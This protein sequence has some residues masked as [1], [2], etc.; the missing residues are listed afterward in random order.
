MS[1]SIPGNRKGSNPRCWYNKF[2][3]TGSNPVLTTNIALW[4]IWLHN[5]LITQRSGSNPRYATG[6]YTVE[7]NLREDVHTLKSG[8]TRDQVVYSVLSD[9]N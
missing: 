5:G 9:K 7:F 4:C 1:G 2:I 8:V 3:H 6:V